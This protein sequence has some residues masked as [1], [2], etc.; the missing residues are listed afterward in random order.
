[1]KRETLVNL[2]L[3]TVIFGY[4]IGMTSY[5]FYRD[6]REKQKDPNYKS[7]DEK[8]YEEA[9]GGEMRWIMEQHRKAQAIYDE[10]NKGHTYG[11]EKWT[12]T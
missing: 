1:M 9:R 4:I 10:R 12:K 6:Y 5:L 2:V 11:G 3:G 7:R 8:M